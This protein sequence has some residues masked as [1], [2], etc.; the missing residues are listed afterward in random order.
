MDTLFNYI[1]DELFLCSYIFNVT[2]SPGSELL[3]F[4]IIYLQLLLFL[5]YVFCVRGVPRRSKI[6]IIN[7]ENLKHLVIVFLRFSIVCENVFYY[8][9]PAKVEV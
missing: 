5:I 1:V 4:L 3:I 7:I 8:L 6:K 2:G 9:L